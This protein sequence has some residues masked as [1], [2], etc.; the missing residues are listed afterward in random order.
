MNWKRK[1]GYISAPSAGRVFS[2]LIEDTTY[3]REFS[4]NTENAFSSGLELIDVFS[5]HGKV[6]EKKTEYLT[7]GP[8]KEAKIEF[9]IVKEIDDFS[10]IIFS[11]SIFGDDTEK[12]IYITIKGFLRVEINDDSFFSKVFA[13]FYFLRLFQGIKKVSVS[14]MKEQMKNIEKEIARISK[15]SL[16]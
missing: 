10:S 6:I 11:F 12:K 5:K 1:T 9:D 3:S 8:R 16:A 4:I 13:E 2:M 15:E 14:L 7:D